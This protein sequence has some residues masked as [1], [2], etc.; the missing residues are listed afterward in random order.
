MI[1]FIQ[2]Y[3]VNTKKFTIV[4]GFLGSQY[5]LDGFLICLYHHKWE[6]FASLT[7]YSEKLIAAGMLPDLFK[8]QFW[9]IARIQRG[10]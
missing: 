8:S 7:Q 2:G 6:F 3:L 5:P 9:Q 10:V 4:W 1:A